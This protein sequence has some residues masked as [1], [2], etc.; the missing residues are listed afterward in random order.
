MK[1]VKQELQEAIKKLKSEW[2]I[3]NANRQKL[4]SILEKVSAAVDRAA[5]LPLP[6]GGGDFELCFIRVDV[7]DPLADFTISAEDAPVGCNPAVRITNR[8]PMV[9]E[10][11]FFNPSTRY[12]HTRNSEGSDFE[13]F[14]GNKVLYN[15]KTVFIPKYA[16]NG[17]TAYGLDG[18]PL[19]GNNEANIV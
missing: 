13:T 19:S 15:G 16:E 2:G 5:A 17:L 9:I 7:I 18:S 4:A 1:Q 8:P 12:F 10:G 14:R 11:G 3:Q 6:D